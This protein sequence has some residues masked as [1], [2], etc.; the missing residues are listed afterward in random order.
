MKKMKMA[1][2]SY[3][4]SKKQQ[5]TDDFLQPKWGMMETIFPCLLKPSM[6]WLKNN[7]LVYDFFTVNK[8]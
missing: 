5:K 4:F 6:E 1:K 2:L 8:K 7:A 3:M